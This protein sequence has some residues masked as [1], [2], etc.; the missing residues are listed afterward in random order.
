MPTDTIQLQVVKNAGAPAIGAITAAFSDSIV[1]QLASS[2]GIKKVKY[3]IYEFPTGFAV[4]AGWT[5]E[6]T[7]VYSVTLANGAPAPAFTLPA[8]GADLRGKYFFDAVANDQ[9]SNGTI[10]GG[11][12]SKAQ[13]N[14]PF[15]S[16][17]ED[18]GYLETNEF[19]AV[20]QY[21][22][23]LK[24]LIRYLDSAILSGGGVLVHGLLSGLTADNHP[25][26][27]LTTG[28]RPLTGDQSAGG[29]KLTNLATPTVST[30]AANK[31]YVDASAGGG[32]DVV[33]PGSSVDDRLA[34]FSGATGKLLKQSALL[35]SRLF[36]RDGSIALTGNIDLGT[37]KAV[38][39][40]NATAATDLTT[41][42]QVESLIAAGV[43]TIA[44]WKA[45]VRAATTA[46]L[47]AN[48]LIGSV[49]TANANGALAAQDGVALIVGNRLLVKNEATGAKN[50]IYTVTAVG[51]VGAPWS[52]TRATDCDINAEV[53]TGLTT[54]VEEGTVAA[55][56]P[57][58]LTTPN[59]IALGA[60]ILTFTLLSSATAGNGLT[61]T[62][63]LAVLP[64]NTTIVVGA[65]GIKR[66]AITG[67]GTI[68]DGSNSLVIT[69]LAWSKIATA[70]GNLGFTGLKSL[71]YTGEVNNT[72]ATPAINF[73]TG[74]L[75]KLTLSTSH[76]P[77][78]VAPAG[79]GWVQVCAVGDGTARTI[80][81]PGSVVGTLPAPTAGSG[82]RTFYPFFYDGT[83]YHYVASSGSSVIAGNGILDTS[84]TWSV[85]PEDSTLV[86]G[87]GGVKRA[88]I[89]GDVTVA[90]GANAAVIAADAVTYPK[91]QNVSAASRALGRGSAGG[92]GDVEELAF[93]GG[94]S[95]SGTN[96]TIADN[97]LS[98]A[99]LAAAIGDLGFTGLKYISYT[100]EYDNGNSSTADTIAWANG[101]HQ[102][103]TLTGN[104]TFTFTPPTG[105]G[106][107]QLKL[108]QDA[109]GSRTVTWPATMIWPAGGAPTLST[110]AGDI[111]IVSIYWDGTN[112]WGT[113]DK[114]RP[115]STNGRVMTTIAGAAVWSMTLGNSTDDFSIDANALRL[116]ATNVQLFGGTAV[117]FGGGDKV[118]HI[119]ANQ[120]Q[121]GTPPANSQFLWSDG[122]G[123]R[124]INEYLGSWTLAPVTHMRRL[125]YSGFVET[126]STTLTT[127]LDFDL[128][129]IGSNTSGILEVYVTCVDTAGRQ[130]Q[131]WVVDVMHQS[132]VLSV[133][134]PSMVGGGTAAG[135][136]SIVASGTHVLIRITAVNSTNYRWDAMAE[137][138]YGYLTNAAA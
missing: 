52:L 50:G 71:S 47:P 129:G 94:L 43:G 95:V 13:A 9:R 104:C 60:S 131:K 51:S 118:L 29:H 11:L 76:T 4:P 66:A 5:A 103:S 127:I 120:T 72:G 27:L 79:V 116:G 119:G 58:I 91:I 70:I 138:T 81:W 57:Y 44:D 12:R 3:R 93:T 126:S 25:Q 15:S 32:G 22:G 137:L 109:T 16:G 38:N 56:K 20:R 115:S 78:F 99:K 24:R 28:A 100:A 64:E 35:V 107:I 82:V 133:G 101:L 122:S 55:G 37:N 112:Y 6:A 21:V 130:A 88:A 87:A 98:W 42:Q 83:N 92:A 97:A 1:L 102:K 106:T 34:L 46:A 113:S 128:F 19:D 90:A 14:I 68:A 132:S 125:A 89:T 45:S 65:S 75:Q 67:D 80:T 30:D 61:G 31:A 62:S 40:G 17:L 85:K 69:N 84:G 26:Y 18:I 10:V 54:V 134:T 73:T 36:L 124:T 63:S 2:S 41:L 74:D 96:I 49:L 108:I 23:P 114:L 8:A 48:T 7:N 105:V 53:T 121:P 123:L 117:A 77:T 111:D 86:V 59:P 39:A 33:G 135:T 110:V 136:V